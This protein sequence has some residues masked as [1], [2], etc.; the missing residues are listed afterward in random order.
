MRLNKIERVL[1]FILWK[2]SSQT[3]TTPIQYKFTRETL[4]L[5]TIMSPLSMPS[6]LVSWGRATE[7][8]CMVGTCAHYIACQLGQRAL[9][10]PRG[11]EADE[12]I[13]GSLL[14]SS[15]QG[16]PMEQICLVDLSRLGLGRF[17]IHA[18][19]AWLHRCPMRCCY[20]LLNWDLKIVVPRWWQCYGSE[21][22]RINLSIGCLFAMQHRILAY[23]A[24]QAYYVHD[25]NH[26]NAYIYYKVTIQ[27]T[28]T[29]I[30]LFANKFSYSCGDM[31]FMNA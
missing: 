11:V 31:I 14:G 25:L 9:H 12:V 10:T 17:Q 8:W 15:L 7:L 29:I 3:Y 13:L 20:T 19:V 18:M 26:S 30:I 2:A 27:I 23:I 21:Y 24:F 16:E 1:Y 22:L 6:T 5:L 4:A 28:E